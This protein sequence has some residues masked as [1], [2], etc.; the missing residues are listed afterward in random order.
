MSRPNTLQKKRHICTDTPPTPPQRT[1]ICTRRP[2]DPISKPP[3]L[4]GHDEHILRVHNQTVRVGQ[5][6]RLRLRRRR[7]HARHAPGVHIGRELRRDLEELDDDLRR[8]GVAV[9]ERELAVGPLLEVVRVREQGGL[10]G[11]VGPG[12]VGFGQGVGLAGEGGPAV[13]ELA[14]VDGAD[15]AVAHAELVVGV[16]PG[17]ARGGGEVDLVAGTSGGAGPGGQGTVEVGVEVDGGVLAGVDGDAVAESAD[18]GLGEGAARDFDH[19]A[20]VLRAGVLE[21]DGA[22][23]CHCQDG[24]DRGEDAE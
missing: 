17:G 9:D 11:R 8:V 3:T 21:G 16:V 20:D 6:D 14:V 23:G 5:L 4:V 18:G 1:T 24:G 2:F 10:V 15:G 7:R 13:G 12:G 22:G 19:V